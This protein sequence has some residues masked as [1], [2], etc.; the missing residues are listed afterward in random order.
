[1]ANC[2][3]RFKTK[4]QTISHLKIKQHACDIWKLKEEIKAV[5]CPESVILERE[6]SVRKGMWVK[7]E[8]EK[9]ER[10]SKQEGKTKQ[11][12]A[13]KIVE[14]FKRIGM[15]GDRKEIKQLLKV[16]DDENESTFY[17]LITKNINLIPRYCLEA[18]LFL[19][20]P[21]YTD[22]DTQK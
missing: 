8:E 7:A 5:L 15:R 6:K 19:N 11:C 12:E 9:E 3:K 4:G 22:K 10:G 2:K 13:S 18:Q 20:S 1:M 14:E 21:A 17:K 16:I